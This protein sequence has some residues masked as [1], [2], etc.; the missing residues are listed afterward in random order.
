MPALLAR[1][2]RSGI[3]RVEL[4]ILAFIGPDSERGRR[5]A[6]AAGQ[7]D[8][9]FDFAKLLLLNQGTE[10]DGWL[11]EEMIARA[12]ASI[13]GLNVPQLPAARE[14]EFVRSQAA[15]V[16][17]L[18]QADRVTGTPTIL[19]GKRGAVPT[20]VQ[21]SSPADAQSVAAA[22]ERAAGRRG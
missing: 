9:M 1:Y 2:V 16:D 13:P 14:R 18:A 6:I 7:Q 17:A 4:Q 3:A 20:P 22:I 5:A 12:A 10:N 21:L 19:V 15:R 11:S 8:R